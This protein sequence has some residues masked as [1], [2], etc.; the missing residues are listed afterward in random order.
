[1]L[2]ITRSIS[3]QTQNLLSISVRFLNQP[4]IK[5]NIKNIA[6]TVTF[7]FGLIELHDIYQI[8]RNR[9]ITTEPCSDYPKWMQVANKVIIVCTKIS[10]ILS[11]GVSRP[12]VFIISSIVGCVFTTAQLNRVFGPNTTFAINPWHP[13]HVVSFVAV[14]LAMPSLAQSAYNGINWT[15]KKIQQHQNAPTNEHWLTDAKIRLMI[16]F[17]TIT[18]R[19]VL[20]MGNKLSRLMLRP[21]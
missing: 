12:G 11:A 17:N 13:R 1:M 18:S 21:T 15:I 6:G 7:A 19:P 5:E 20:H 8:L 9:E 2:A 3:G 4:I 10:L 14:I 16:L